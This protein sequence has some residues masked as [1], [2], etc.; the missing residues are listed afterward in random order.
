[1]GWGGNRYDLKGVLYSPHLSNTYS[2]IFPTL[3]NSNTN[4]LELAHTTEVKGSVLQDYLFFFG[5]THGMQKFMGQ[6]SNCSDNAKFLTCWATREVHGCL[7]D[8]PVTS[9][10]YL[11]LCLADQGFPCPFPWV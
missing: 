2:V 8:S 9:P 7:L 11:N 5:C 10:G 6:G 4:Y 3:S 1:M